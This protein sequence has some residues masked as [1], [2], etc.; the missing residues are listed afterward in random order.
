M[1]ILNNAGSS[2]ICIRAC[3]SPGNRQPAGAGSQRDQ[4]AGILQTTRD[5]DA[6]RVHTSARQPV[7]PTACHSIQHAS[8]NRDTDYPAGT[9]S[10]QSNL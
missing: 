7:Q 4:Y 9:G 8:S 5:D 3:S 2:Y 1:L 10:A 6:L